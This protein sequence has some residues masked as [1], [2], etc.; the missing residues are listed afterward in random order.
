MDTT[1]AGTG[2]A[3]GAPETETVGALSHVPVEVTVRLARTTMALAEVLG[4]RRGEVLSLNQPV[5][6]PVELVA[7][8]RVFATGELVTVDGQLGLRILEIAPDVVLTE[9]SA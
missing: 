6:E 3:V 9:P 8:G 1:V 5:G 7:A 4:L 2:A